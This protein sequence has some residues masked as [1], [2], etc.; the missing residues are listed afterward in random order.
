MPKY[1]IAFRLYS[2]GI[3]SGGE[4]AGARISSTHSKQEMDAKLS[5]PNVEASDLNDA[6][7]LLRQEYT[8]KAQTIV[9]SLS[10]VT[11]TGVVLGE[12]YEPREVGRDSYEVSAGPTIIGPFAVEV[13]DRIINVVSERV[14]DNDRLRRALHW[15]NLGLNTLDP[16][17]KLVALWTGLEASVEQESMFS[18]EV[19]Q[20]FETEKDRLLSN[21]DDEKDRTNG[22]DAEEIE[23]LRENF[24]SSFG[25][26][27]KESIQQALKRVF[28]DEMGGSKL[29]PHRGT[30][31]A[32]D[33]L[34]DQIGEL[35]D[36]RVDIVHYGRR[37]PNAAAK[38]AGTHELLRRWLGREFSEVYDEFLTDE[39][40]EDL[41]GIS[42][43]TLMDREDALELLFDGAD[44]TLS[45][46]E[47]KI[48]TIA[49][50]RDYADSYQAPVK[51]STGFYDLLI[52]RR[53]GYAFDPDP[54]WIDEPHKPLLEYLR[55]AGRVPLDVV[56]FNLNTDEHLA[57]YREPLG[58]E[59]EIKRCCDELVEA[60]LV[61]HN[62][63]GYRITGD[64][65]QCVEGNA[66]LNQ[67]SL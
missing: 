36:A 47:L 45:E 37:V 32:G 6:K 56:M 44:D 60:G 26:V 4:I 7:Q 33:S 66:S 49:F 16:E 12:P 2:Q 34:S 23:K 42:A 55:G 30:S 8:D 17:D 18:T 67:F 9:S 53:G 48:R 21:L 40:P 11:E 58:E 28:V 10:W 41:R 46:I 22:S 59:E 39:V 5:F 43:H 51:E 20:I 52:Q 3:V 35:K 54:D 64:G 14:N 25:F 57:G 1:N 29:S 63:N 27:K 31:I 50:S 38:A 15:Y 19:E 24:A 61:D 65:K 62:E 13:T